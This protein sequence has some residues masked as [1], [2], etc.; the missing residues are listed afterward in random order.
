M[1]RKRGERRGVRKGKGLR[2]KAG[3][4]TALSRV[5]HRSVGLALPPVGDGRSSTAP[6]LLGV[7]I[8]ARATCWCACSLTAATRR[9]V[10][11]SDESQAHVTSCPPSLYFELCSRVAGTRGRANRTLRLAVV[12]PPCMASGPARMRARPPATDPL[13]WRRAVVAAQPCVKP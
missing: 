5:R 11:C 9:G 7:K 4:A 6:K 13:C 2:A 1:E 12:L 10:V 8:H 3:R